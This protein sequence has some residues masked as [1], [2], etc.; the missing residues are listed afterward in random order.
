MVLVAYLARHH[1][2]MDVERANVWARAHR[3]QIISNVAARPGVIEYLASV[4]SDGG[5]TEERALQ[6]L[7]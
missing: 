4:S 6:A 3:R 2:H 1:M 7:S 5:P